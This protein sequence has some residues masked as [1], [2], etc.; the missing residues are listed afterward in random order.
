[1]G[2]HGTTVAFW[3]W[4][5]NG[6]DDWPEFGRML[7]ARGA[8]HRAMQEQVVMKVDST[9][10]PLMRPFPSEGFELSDEFF[11]VPRVLEKGSE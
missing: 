2:I 11:R 1:M 8:N 10:H 7:G 4:G 9:G 3:R 6:G 5:A